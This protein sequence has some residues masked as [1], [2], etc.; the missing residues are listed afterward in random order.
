MM[1]A[2]GVFILLCVFMSAARMAIVAL[3]LAFLIS[4]LWGVL[5]RPGRAFGFLAMLVVL[6]LAEAYPA[7]LL[8]VLAVVLIASAKNTDAD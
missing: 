6:K 5:Y 2:I 3:T 8:A 1:R 4:L 7:V